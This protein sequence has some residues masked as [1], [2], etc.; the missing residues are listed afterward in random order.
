MLG[1]FSDVSPPLREF[2]AGSDFSHQFPSNPISMSPAY[3][4]PTGPSTWKIN[5]KTSL[6]EVIQRY[7][8]QNVCLL[9]FCLFDGQSWFEPILRDILVCSLHPTV[10]PLCGCGFQT[11][12]T[13]LQK[14]EVGHRKKTVVAITVVPSS[15]FKMKMN[16]QLENMYDYPSVFKKQTKKVVTLF[17]FHNDFVHPCFNGDLSCLGP[18]KWGL[19]TP[20]P[21]HPCNLVGY[22]SWPAVRTSHRK[23]PTL[24]SIQVKGRFSSELLSYMGLVED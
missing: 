23:T 24:S 22:R 15:S 3:R 2:P 8:A 16:I 1:W 18:T 4:P 7:R 11:L 13:S 17:L 5:I 20:S 14:N 19:K 12:P 10:C 9:F 6:G 21:C